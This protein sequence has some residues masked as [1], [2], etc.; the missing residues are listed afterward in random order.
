VIH[1]NRWISTYILDILRE[2]YIIYVA[3]GCFQ[4]M[5]GQNIRRRWYSQRCIVFMGKVFRMKKL[6]LVIISAV[7]TS[8]ISPGFCSAKKY[9]SPE[10]IR[11]ILQL[12]AYI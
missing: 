12:G 10:K 6:R 8:L 3:F 9:L 11:V 1:L 5:E 4:R 2:Q 7:I